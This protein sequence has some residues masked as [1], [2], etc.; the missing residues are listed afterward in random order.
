MHEIV[1][2][3]GFEMNDLTKV[4][5]KAVEMERMKPINRRIQL[6]KIEVESETKDEDDRR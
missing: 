5:R 4:H 6:T 1:I 3:K 2:H